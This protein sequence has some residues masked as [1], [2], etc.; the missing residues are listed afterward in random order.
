M[1]SKIMYIEPGGGLAGAGGRIGRVTFSQTGKTIRYAGSEFQSLKGDGFKENFRDIET[2]EW[3]WISGPRRDG[4]DAL[5]PMTV[6]IDEDVREE[7]WCEI[8]KRPDLKHTSSYRSTGKHSRRKPQPELS[9]SGGTKSGG[10]RAGWGM[11]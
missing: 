4:N 6:E 1:K 9:A 7:Y 3:Y 2:G 10:N 8:R 5:Y 11:R